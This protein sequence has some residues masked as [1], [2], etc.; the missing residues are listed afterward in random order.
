LPIKDSLSLVLPNQPKAKLKS[1]ILSK[2]LPKFA[3]RVG[4]QQ[5]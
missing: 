3:N 2:L 5:K 1:K 4:S